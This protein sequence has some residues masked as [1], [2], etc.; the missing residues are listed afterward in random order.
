MNISTTGLRQE[1]N[2]DDM[3]KDYTCGDWFSV[4]DLNTLHERL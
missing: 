1:R 2:E 4:L 3:E